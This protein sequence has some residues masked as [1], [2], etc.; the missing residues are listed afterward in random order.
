MTPVKTNHTNVI[1]VKDQDGVLPLP[2]FKDENGIVV[3]TFEI[4]DKELEKLNL[5]KQIHLMVYTYNATLQPVRLFCDFNE[6]FTDDQEVD[7]A[8][9]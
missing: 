7:E 6:I 3:A 9:K 2:A 1:F 4:T 5:H 8:S